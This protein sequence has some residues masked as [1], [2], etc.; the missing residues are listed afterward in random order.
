MDIEPTESLVLFEDNENNQPRARGSTQHL[1]K[2]GQN[3][4]SSSPG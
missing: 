2:T 1:E 3:E 4:N